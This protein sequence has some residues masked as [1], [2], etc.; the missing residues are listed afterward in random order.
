PQA[1]H[2]RARRPG[3]RG[4]LRHLHRRPAPDAHRCGRRAGGLRRRGLPDHRG[5]PR[6]LGAAGQ[7]R[8]GCGRR[9][10]RLHGRIRRP[11]RA[12]HRRRRPG[13][14]RRPGQGDRL[15]GRRA[16]GRGGAGAGGGGAGARPPLGQRGPPPHPDPRTPGAG[17]HGRT[18]GADPVRSLPGGRR[19]HQPGRRAP[20]RDGHHRV[21]RPQGAPAHRGRHHPLSR[22]P[23]P[24]G[25]ERTRATIPQISS[26]RATRPSSTGTSTPTPKP[27]T[28]PI[29]PT[30]ATATSE[31]PSHWTV[32]CWSWVTVI[33]PTG[34]YSVPST[35]AGTLD[36]SPSQMT[37]PVPSTVHVVEAASEVGTYTSVSAVE[38][39]STVPEAPPIVAGVAPSRAT[40]ATR[41]PATNGITTSP[42]ALAR[43]PRIPKMIR[44]RPRF[45]RGGSNW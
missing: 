35:V 43:S 1:F 14:L 42:I 25:Q 17:G 33:E 40:T 8:G 37:S 13:S 15:R 38:E 41:T 30:S 34:V 6:H 44:F 18:A 21:H 32:T 28:V 19:R 7:R 45:L 29:T 39:A 20:S 11:L 16:D 5:D 3:D 9:P 36:C 24:G 27:I 23:L 10:P 4:R 2:L 22:G 26:A 31:A 12:R